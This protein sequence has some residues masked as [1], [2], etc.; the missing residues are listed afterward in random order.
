MAQFD[1]FRPGYEL[2]SVE[3]EWNVQVPFF[4]TTKGKGQ[5]LDSPVFSPQETPDS[6]WQLYVSDTSHSLGIYAFHCNSTE[7]GVNFFEPVLVKMSILNN[8]RQKV[9]Q[10]MV[11]SSATSTNYVE[12]H[13][14][15]EDLIKSNSQQSY[16]SLSLYFKILTHV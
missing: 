9:F 8:R 12:F 6:K 3:M 1:W 2:V 16:G 13:L 4:Q 10:Q 15:K 7:E 11:S 5:R 14:S